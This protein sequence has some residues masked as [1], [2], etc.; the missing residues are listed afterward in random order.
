M[1]TNLVR[2]SGH[3]MQDSIRQLEEEQENSMNYANTTH[4]PRVDLTSQ[5]KEQLAYYKLQFEHA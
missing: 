3:F 2:P 4:L 5:D 1:A